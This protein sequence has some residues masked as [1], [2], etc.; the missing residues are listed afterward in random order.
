MTKEE[1]LQELKKLAEDTYDIE[2][3]HLTA[4]QALLLYINDEDIIAAY[5]LINKWYA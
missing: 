4:D 2:R 5:D 3:N 1:L